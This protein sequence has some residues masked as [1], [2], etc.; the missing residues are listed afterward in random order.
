MTDLVRTDLYTL[1]AWTAVPEVFRKSIIARIPEGA[2][3]HLTHGGKSYRARVYV[4][5]VCIAESLP[6]VHVETA[7]WQ[8]LRRAEEAA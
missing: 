2:F 7:C 4:G 5:T 6:C 1:P 8:A 3:L